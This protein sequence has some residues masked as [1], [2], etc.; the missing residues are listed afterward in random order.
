M[1][2]SP[3]DIKFF[4]IGGV[5]FDLNT[6]EHEILRN[7]FDEPRIHFAINCASKSCPKLRHEAYLTK[8]LEFQLED[9]AKAFINDRSKNRISATEM[10]LSSIFKWFEV[11]FT[12]DGSIMPYIQKYHSDVNSNNKISYMDYDW[13]LNK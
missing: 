2:D 8:Y 4:K 7:Q 1:I 13:S 5:D 11:D 12:K 6:I 9:Q 3:W 10:E